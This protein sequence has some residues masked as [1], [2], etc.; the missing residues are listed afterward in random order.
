MAPSPHQQLSTSYALSLKEALAELQKMEDAA[1]TVAER[2][3][4][5]EDFAR[6]KLQRD[7]LTTA[8]QL[9]ADCLCVGTPSTRKAPVGQ[10]QALF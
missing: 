9:V 1:S 5:T 3:Q 6:R 8:R 2:A 10:Q 4:G 7:A